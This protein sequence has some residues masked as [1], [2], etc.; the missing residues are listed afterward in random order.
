MV[1]ESSTNKV[2]FVDVDTGTVCR[3]VELLPL[4]NKTFLDWCGCVALL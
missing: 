3:G 4:R 1:W 2:G